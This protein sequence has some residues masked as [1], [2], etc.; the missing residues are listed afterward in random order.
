LSKVLL[1]VGMLEK[2]E[3]RRIASEAG[4]PVFN[5]PDSVEICFVPSGDYR[6]LLR[7]QGGLGKP[8][9]II[10]IDGK[11]LATHD[12][13]AGFTRGQRRGLG[14]AASCPMYVLD[15]NPD[16]GDVLVGPR[17]ATGCSGAV[18]SSFQTF[19][20]ELPASS[21]WLNVK[22]Q[23]R[24]TPGGVAARVRDL[25]GG[26]IEVDFEHPADSVNPGQGLAIYGGEQ[27]LGGGWIESTKLECGF[28]V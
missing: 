16:T 24:S 27:L 28:R 12:G 23:F 1:P 9:R 3:T 18:V 6:E 7:A 5:K 22:A 17:E 8:G 11:Q 14:F 15:I 20:F 21:Q 2:S 13:H 19:A 26:R 4:L 10:D 25:G